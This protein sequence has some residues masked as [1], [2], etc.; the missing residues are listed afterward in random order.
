M[1]ASRPARSVSMRRLDAQGSVTLTL[2]EAVRALAQEALAP[3]L[4]R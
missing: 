2:D 4:R 1:I 3:D